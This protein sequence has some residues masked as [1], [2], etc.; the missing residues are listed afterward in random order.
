MPKVLCIDDHETGLQVR[1]LLLETKGYEVLTAA[2]GR[3][4]AALLAEHADIAA[5]I[6]DYSM[7]GQSGEEVAKLI[8]EQWPAVKIIMLSGYSEMPQAAMDATDAFIRKG[9]SPAELLEALARLV[10][11]RPEPRLQPVVER[12]RELIKKSEDA[13]QRLRAA[14]RQRRR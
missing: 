9:S 11:E 2:S 10:G 7:P 6:L 14:R 4:G 1:R 3:Q 13:L 5:V 8:R 12:S